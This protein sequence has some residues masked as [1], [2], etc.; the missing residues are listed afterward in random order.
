MV[1]SAATAP[2]LIIV[3]VLMMGA[4]TGINFEDFTEAFPA[5]LTIV[6][7]PFAY[8]IASGIAAGFISYPIV[9]LVSG[10]GKEVHWLVYILALASLLHFIA[11]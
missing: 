3:G 5:F 11:H 6:F 8:S 7:M 1:P 4:V 2:A 9:K 10:K